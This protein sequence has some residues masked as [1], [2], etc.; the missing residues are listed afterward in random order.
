MIGSE[1]L[2]IKHDQYQCGRN[3]SYMNI[4]HYSGVIAELLYIIS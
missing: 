4:K 2:D 3:Y 1:L